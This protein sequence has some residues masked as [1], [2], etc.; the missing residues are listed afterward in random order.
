MKSMAAYGGL[1]RRLG[2]LGIGIEAPVHP[3]NPCN[4]WI[5]TDP[6]GMEG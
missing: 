1:R 4:T 2:A 3:R 5:T 6:A